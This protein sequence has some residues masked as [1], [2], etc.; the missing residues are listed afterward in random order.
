[1][2]PEK[3]DVQ[4]SFIQLSGP[5]PCV[6]I[7]IKYEFLSSCNAILSP[8][9]VEKERWVDWMLISNTELQ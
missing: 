5:K 7:S 1:M 9:S 4:Q 3:L 8:F 2:R 6:F